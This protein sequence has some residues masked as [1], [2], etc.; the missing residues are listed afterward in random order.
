MSR[1]I[2]RTVRF[3]VLKYYSL[4][5]TVYRAGYNMYRMYVHRAGIS[6]L[7]DD[8]LFCSRCVLGV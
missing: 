2:Y 6:Y 5:A 8:I 7:L 1:N 4:R 3:K